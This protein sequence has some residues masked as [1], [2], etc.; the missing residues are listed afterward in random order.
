MGHTLHHQGLPL[1][2]EMIQSELAEDRVRDGGTARG[3]AA[4]EDGGAAA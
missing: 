3:P 1:D 4:G 2:E